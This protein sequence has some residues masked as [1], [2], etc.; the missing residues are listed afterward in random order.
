MA[1]EMYDRAPR[2]NRGGWEFW[3]QWVPTEFVYVRQSD[4]ARTA[5]SLFV[6]Q[7]QLDEIAV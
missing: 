5:P 4:S 7:C 6:R 2:A 3:H 1:Q